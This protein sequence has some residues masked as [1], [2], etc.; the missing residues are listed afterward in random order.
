MNNTILQ[1]IRFLTLSAV[2]TWIPVL[3]AAEPMEVRWNEVCRV[4]AGHQLEITT[5]AGDTVGGYC[6]TINVDEI[7][8]TTQDRRVVKIARAALSRIQM[9]RS[10]N[11]HGLNSL[12]QGMHE[13]L[14]QGF[15]WLFSPYAPLGM[16]VVPG[17]VAWG[18]VAAP[19]C[20]LGDLNDKLAGRREIKVI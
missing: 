20:L 13:G 2:M 6:V 11:G 3:H 4:S 7:S 16:V 17:T 14:R 19:F 5:T 12:R 18:A 9:H 1:S 8:V 15:E 10:K